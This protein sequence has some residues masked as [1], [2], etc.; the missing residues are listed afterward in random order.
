M[1]DK[2]EK[3]KRKSG[4]AKKEDSKTEVTEKPVMEAQ[5][6]EVESKDL[7]MSPYARVMRVWREIET[8][9]G[10]REAIANIFD[11]RNGRSFTNLYDCV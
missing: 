3:G 9:E 2:K 10:Q 4:R 5:D 6:A 1:A 8:I 7:S 11:L